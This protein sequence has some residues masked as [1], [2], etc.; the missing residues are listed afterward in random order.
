MFVFEWGVVCGEGVKMVELNHVA[1]GGAGVIRFNLM[2][3]IRAIW[4]LD[5]EQAGV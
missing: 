5:V 2:V 4:L 1:R 3:F